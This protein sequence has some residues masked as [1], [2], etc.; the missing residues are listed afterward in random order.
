MVVLTIPV[1]VDIKLI[2]III[3]P[4]CIREIYPWKYI[5][6]IN[7]GFRFQFNFNYANDSILSEVL[8]SRIFCILTLLFYPKLYDLANLFANLWDHFDAILFY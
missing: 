3:R 7:V 6:P 5:V 4:G 2:I 1:C 8:L